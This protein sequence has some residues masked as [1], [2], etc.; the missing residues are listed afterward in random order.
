GGDGL[1]YPAIRA[2]FAALSTAVA[3]RKPAFSAWPAEGGRNFEPARDLYVE[4]IFDVA[5]YVRREFRVKPGK[6]FIW[7]HSQGGQFAKLC[8]LEHPSF[9]ASY[10]SQA[11]SLVG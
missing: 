2:P 1:I 5:E 3:L 11:G 10:F 9:V 8:A 6:I 4:W 7:G